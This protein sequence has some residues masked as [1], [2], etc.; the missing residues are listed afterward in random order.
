MHEV[1]ALSGDMVVS[2]CM[3]SPRMFCMLLARESMESLSLSRG[4][5]G[6]AVLDGF[7]ESPRLVSM[8]LAVAIDNEVGEW[9]P[10]AT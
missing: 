4:P 8:A 1:L 10:T 5:A 3:V 2:M 9:E 6:S 7:G